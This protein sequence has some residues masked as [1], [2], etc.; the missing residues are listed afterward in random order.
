M[1]EAFLQDSKATMIITI[2]HKK[3]VESNA[4]VAILRPEFTADLT[5]HFIEGFCVSYSFKF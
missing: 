5:F 1:E 3:F 2:G 4:I